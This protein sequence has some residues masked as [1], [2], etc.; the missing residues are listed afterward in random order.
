MS[1][2]DLFGAEHVEPLK[3]AAAYLGGKR[4]LARQLVPLIDG[5]DHVAYA[6]PFVGMGGVFFRRT[7]GRPRE[8]INDIDGDIANFFRVLKWHYGPLV[9]LMRFDVTSRSEF[10]WLKAANPRSMTDLQRAAR[11]LYLQ[12]LYFGGGASQT[13]GVSPQYPAR[14]DV[15]TIGAHIERLH[16]RLRRVVIEQLDF[17]EFIRRYDCADMLFY[18]DPPYWG[19]E[20]DYGKGKFE[21]AD[22][23]RLA[24]QLAGIAGRFILSINDR[25]EI[26]EIFAAFEMREVELT[27]TVA[28]GEGTPAKE[29][30]VTHGV[31]HFRG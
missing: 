12:T 8:F 21:R 26:R 3:P 1:G 22:F 30:I 2:K 9:D 14:F 17:S 31:F 27:Y 10:D 13:F 20:R 7:I 11:F 18:L 19:G 25:P 28:K 23:R 29:L 16:E 24:E 4:I 6:E 5:L 15:V